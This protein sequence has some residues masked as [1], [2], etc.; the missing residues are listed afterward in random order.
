[1]LPPIDDSEGGLGAVEIEQPLGRSATPATVTV[2]AANEDVAHPAE[3]HGVTAYVC[4]CAL[5]VELAGGV[6][7]PLSALRPSGTPSRVQ[8][9]VVS[10]LP[11]AQVTP[12]E[13]GPLDDA[14]D[15]G[16]AVAVHPAGT[17][18]HTMP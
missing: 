7:L 9:A 17:L 10:G 15:V 12:S 13:T 1:M 5:A 8:L 6:S 11:A 16:L 18:V 3:L 14:S 2:G 4:A